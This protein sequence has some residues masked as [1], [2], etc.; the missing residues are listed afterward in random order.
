MNNTVKYSVLAL[1]ILVF[2]GAGYQVTGQD[3]QPS[4]AVMQNVIA[5]ELEANNQKTSQQ[6]DWNNV[7]LR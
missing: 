2:L 7:P 6:R 5:P 1:F 3:P 4:Q